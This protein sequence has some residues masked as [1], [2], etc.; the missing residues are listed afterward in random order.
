MDPTEHSARRQLIEQM[1]GASRLMVDVPAL[2]AAYEAADPSLDWESKSYERVPAPH[3]QALAI[4]L[5]NGMGNRRAAQLPIPG[6]RFCDDLRRQMIPWPGA[7]SG[8]EIC[9]WRITCRPSGP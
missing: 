1:L 6:A 2:L 9:R 8:C 3:G 4:A 5:R 7:L